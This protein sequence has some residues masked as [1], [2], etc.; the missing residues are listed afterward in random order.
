M[1]F[2]V[3]GTLKYICLPVLSRLQ[4]KKK[5]V[6]VLLKMSTSR[7]VY[8]QRRRT[9]RLERNPDFSRCAMLLNTGTQISGILAAT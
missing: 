2:N 8:A 6:H 9:F 5:E 4:I 7:G 3:L 1:L